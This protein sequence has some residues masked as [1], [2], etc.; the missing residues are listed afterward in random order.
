MISFKK[1]YQYSLFEN[2]T[3]EEQ[4]DIEE[5][6]L[7]KIST[8]GGGHDHPFKSLNLPAGHS[9]PHASKC[10]VHTEKDEEGNIKIVKSKDCEYECYASK[11]ERM[12]AVYEQRRH[13]FDLLKQCKSSDEMAYLIY[14]SLMN[15]GVHLTDKYF[16]I[17]DSGDFFNQ[18][19]FDAWIKVAKKIPDTVFY[20]FTKSLPYWAKRKEHLPS[21]L[22]LIA[23]YGGLHDEEI[24]KHSFPHVK[25]FKSEDEAKNAGYEV[26]EDDV[27]ALELGS[28]ASLMHGTQTGSENVKAAKANAI[29]NKEALDKRRNTKRH[30]DFHQF[31]D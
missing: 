4:S 31:E 22:K 5:R 26:S 9:C 8:G 27:H 23:S 13:N 1:H 20:A 2:I 12:P 16:R 24:V 7:L 28:S 11:S 6:G 18:D 3:P 29:R 10:K 30:I 21:N 17:H 19:Y 15:K 14:K 25:V